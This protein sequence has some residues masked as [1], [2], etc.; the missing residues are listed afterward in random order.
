M[1][2]SLTHVQNS[3]ALVI[4]KHILD[5]EGDHLGDAQPGAE[6]NRNQRPVAGCVR[7]GEEG[8]QFGLGDDGVGAADC[9][10]RCLERRPYHVTAEMV[11]TE[12]P[13]PSEQAA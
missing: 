6:E 4:F 7:G 8:E 11:G 9:G 13:R 3:T 12:C 1:S 5:V 2:F 10:A